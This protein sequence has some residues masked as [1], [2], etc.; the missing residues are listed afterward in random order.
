[1]RTS[2]APAITRAEADRLIDLALDGEIESD[3]G[4][5]DEF[6]NALT[7][8]AT[9]ESPALR[10]RALDAAHEIRDREIAP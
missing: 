6:D 8:L 4:A 10:A 1:M 7:L 2:D 9:S 3:T 5:S